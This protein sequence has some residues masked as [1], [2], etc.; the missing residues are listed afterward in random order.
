MPG[1][2]VSMAFHGC[3]LKRSSF[4]RV[5]VSHLWGLHF[6]RQQHVGDFITIY[7]VTEFCVSLLILIKPFRLSWL[8]QLYFDSEGNMVG[9]CYVSFVWLQIQ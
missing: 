5:A 4:Q 1:L 8:A 6:G 3:M 2:I 7:D 9:Y